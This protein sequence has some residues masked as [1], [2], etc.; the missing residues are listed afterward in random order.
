GTAGELGSAIAKALQKREIAATDRSTSPASNT[1][2]GT[3]ERMETDGGKLR[4]RVDWRLFD[5]AGRLI[6]ERSEHAE[7]PA[8]EWEKGDAAAVGQLAEAS[9]AALAGLMQGEPA[10]PAA[11]SAAHGGGRGRGRVRTR[12]RAP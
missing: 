2:R 7:A 8:G 12:C 1:L 11:P 4:L 3:I 10:K 9:A 6:G 5:P